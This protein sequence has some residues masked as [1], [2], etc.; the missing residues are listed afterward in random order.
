MLWVRLQPRVHLRR[1]ATILTGLDVWTHGLVVSVGSQAI[2]KAVPCHP[3]TSS[4]NRFNPPHAVSPC[5]SM[6]KRQLSCHHHPCDRPAQPRRGHLEVRVDALPSCHPCR[7]PACRWL[8]RWHTAMLCAC[9][10]HSEVD[11]RATATGLSAALPLPHPVW[12]RG[13]NIPLE[14]TKKSVCERC[15]YS[16]TTFCCLQTTEVFSVCAPSPT[17]PHP[18]PLRYLKRP[19]GCTATFLVHGEGSRH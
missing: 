13:I 16:F 9:T 17:P 4:S 19:S 7:S 6:V 5:G 2:I 18:I 10:K 8:T 14:P 15:K 1:S 11:L 3:C 12:S